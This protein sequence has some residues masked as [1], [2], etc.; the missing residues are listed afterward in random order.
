[1]PRF[2]TQGMQEEERLGDEYESPLMLW[3]GA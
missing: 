2:K 3:E 1:M